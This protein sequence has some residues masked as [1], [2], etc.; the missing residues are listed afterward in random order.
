MTPDQ[1]LLTF[2]DL[3]FEVTTAALKAALARAVL[4]KHGNHLGRAALVLHIHRNTLARILSASPERV[5]GYEQ[6]SIEAIR[7]RKADRERYAGP[8]G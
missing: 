7:D 5:T 6:V 8:S 1:F 3:D 4:K 2:V